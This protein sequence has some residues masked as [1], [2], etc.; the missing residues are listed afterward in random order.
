MKARIPKP[1]DQLPP[2]QQKIIKNYISQHAEE[3][4]ENEEADLQIIWI[5]LACILLHEGFGFG[6]GRL[7][8]F[9]ASWKRIY[10]Q[11]KKI[12]TRDEQ[13]AWLESEMSKIFP[14]RGFPSDF[15]E[16]MKGE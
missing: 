15:L 11:N 10:R 1:Y 6:E 13:D 9:I 2:S 14:K 12:K 8:Q 4:I 16:S 7:Y 5:K 3:L